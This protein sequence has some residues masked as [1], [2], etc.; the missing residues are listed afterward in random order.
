MVI[1]HYKSTAIAFAPEAIC[2]VVNKYTDH[3]AYTFGHGHSTTTIKY[4]TDLIH[5]HNRNS[6]RFM[7]KIIQ[8]HSEPFRVDLNV[9][10]PKLV[11]AQYHATLPEYQNCRI[12]RNPID[13]F[14]DEFLPRYYD[15]KIRIG[16]APSVIDPTSEW[17]DKGYY[18]TAP[19]LLRLRKKY[20]DIV[21]IDVIT[22]VPLQECLRRKS[23]CNIFIDEVKTASYHRSG[24]ESLAMGQATIC[25][26]SDKVEE[27]MLKASGASSSPFINVYHTEL[28]N[29]LDKLISDGITSILEK[30]FASRLWME[31]YW[32]PE[33]IAGEYV[34]IYQDVLNK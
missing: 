32:N 22:K 8:Y 10:I 1:G 33:V 26:V 13:I 30:G 12:V 14:S 7:P 11:I 16:F 9:P 34:Q 23:L 29:T 2:S 27:V 31:K 6:V 4:G 15:K 3:T 25:S 20:I 24:L 17:A 28:Y 18:E 21:D 19:I 5:Q